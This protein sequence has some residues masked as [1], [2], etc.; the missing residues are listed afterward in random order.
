MGGRGIALVTGGGRGI[1]AATARLLAREGYAV[2]INYAG[3]RASAEAVA[4]DCRQAGVQAFAHA[5]DIADPAEVTGLFA[6][7][8]RELGPV[9]HLVNNAGVIGGATRV[10]D[11]APETIGRVFAV[12]VTGTILCA[13]AAIRRMARRHGGRGGAIVNVS[14]VA[15]TL[16]SPGEYVH[17]AASK[18]AVDTFTI[19][20]A[21]EVGG[22]GIRVNA[23][24]AG[25]TETEIHRR[26]G[27]PDR[28]AAV[29]RTAPLGRAAVPD[30]IAE[31]VAWLLSEKAAYV[32][33]AIL[34]VGG[35]L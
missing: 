30:D 33:G 32:T 2:C 19:G 17:Y 8:D 28:P 34:R 10:E 11:I 6:A 15:A 7:C 9:S 26:S 21:K 1:G 25:T 13:Q 23:I 16:G 4:G 20:L 12:N 3:D 22:D 35:G 27:N 29:A 31:A 24:Q 5:A 18:A 14:S